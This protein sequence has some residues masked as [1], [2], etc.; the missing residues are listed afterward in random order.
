MVTNHTAFS[1][2]SVSSSKEPLVLALASAAA[3][4]RYTRLAR[5]AF[6]V[7]PI[8]NLSTNAMWTDCQSFFPTSSFVTVSNQASSDGEHRSMLLDASDRGYSLCWMAFAV[9]VCPNASSHLRILLGSDC[10]DTVKQKLTKMG[11][12]L[13]AI[14]DIARSTDFTW[15]MYKGIPFT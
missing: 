9:R 12:Q 5:S 4:R 2:S 13:T 15:V 6:A 8:P 3:C 11:E 14:E 7:R 1:R 10:F